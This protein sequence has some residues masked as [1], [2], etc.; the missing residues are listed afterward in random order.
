MALEIEM[1]DD[2]LETAFFSKDFAR[3][4]D[5]LT[6]GRAEQ[7]YDNVWDD[8]KANNDNIQKHCLALPVD[9]G[10]DEKDQN[11]VYQCRY[12][13]CRRLYLTTDG[14]RK[15]ARKKHHSWLMAFPNRH[16]TNYA[17]RIIW[18]MSDTR[19]KSFEIR[20]AKRGIDSAFWEDFSSCLPSI[21]VN[22]NADAFSV[23]EEESS[24]RGWIQHS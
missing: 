4:I 9:K 7:F 16:T 20:S 22:F 11:A 17:Q 14:A 13:G 1:T 24:E 23:K 2:E 3:Y 12:P 18:K 15:H 10:G 5:H 8:F 19:N 21:D 6:D